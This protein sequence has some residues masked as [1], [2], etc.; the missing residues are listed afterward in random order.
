MSRKAKSVD[1]TSLKA[2]LRTPASAR[3]SSTRRS[4]LNGSFI[5][6]EN[7]RSYSLQPPMFRSQT[8]SSRY[9]TVAIRVCNTDSTAFH[10]RDRSFHFTTH[11]LPH[12]PIGTNHRFFGSSIVEA[13]VILKSNWK[14]YRKGLR[15]L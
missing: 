1:A 5:L 3:L 11:V 6:I 7:A 13:C 14:S 12:N 8:Q 9:D 4:L 2:V 15:L 10:S